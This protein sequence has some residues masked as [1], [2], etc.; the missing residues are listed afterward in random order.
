MELPRIAENP[1]LKKHYDDLMNPMETCRVIR[2]FETDDPDGNLRDKL[3]QKTRQCTE[4]GKVF[5]CVTVQDEMRLAKH[6]RNHRIEKYRCDCP[7]EFNSLAS[8]IRHFKLVHSDGR[9]EKCDSCWY[10]NTPENVKLHKESEHH[11]GRRITNLSV[12]DIC[13]KTLND[14]KALYMHKLTH[15]TFTCGICKAEVKGYSSFQTHKKNAHP[16]EPESYPCEVCGKMFNEKMKLKNHFLR[17]HTRIK[18]GLINVRIAEGDLQC[19]GLYR[20]IG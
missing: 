19:L 7:G 12:C 17:I 10:I 20:L 1:Y 15:K 8:K 11:Y 6:R 16:K 9:F 14:G 13:G 18:I 5:T 2:E 4:C 3:L